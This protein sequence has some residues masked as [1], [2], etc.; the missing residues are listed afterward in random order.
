MPS[1]NCVGI[2]DRVITDNNIK[3]LSKMS[4]YISLNSLS[5]A[6]MIFDPHRIH[7]EDPTIYGNKRKHEIVPVIWGY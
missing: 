1:L 6:Y 7:S 3:T 2:L 4:G 5:L